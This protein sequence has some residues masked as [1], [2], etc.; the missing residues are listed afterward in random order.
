MKIHSKLILISSFLLTGCYPC[1][2][3]DWNCN[4]SKEDTWWYKKRI[5]CEKEQKN[6]AKEILRSKYNEKIDIHI[7]NQ[8]ILSNGSY[9]FESD[10]NILGEQ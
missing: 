9:K 8:C 6:L 10:K 5:R 3:L 7:L 2:F 4:E 1:K